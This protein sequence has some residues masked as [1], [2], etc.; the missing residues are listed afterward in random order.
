MNK[1]KIVGILVFLLS[2]CLAF[3]F[4]YIS[5]QNKIHTETLA[6]I[7]EQKSY[8]QEIS[9]AVFYLSKNRGTSSKELEHHIQNFIANM[10]HKKENSDEHTMLVKKWKEFYALVQQFQKENITT[11]LYS[12]ILTDTLVN[13][14]YMKN[15]DIILLFDHFIHTK[16]KKYD[17]EIENYKRLEY[18]LFLVIG[19]L[20]MY[21][22]SQ[23]RGV[24]SFIYTFTETSKN[25][26]KRESIKGLKP[27]KIR[28][29]DN[30]T[31]EATQNY[32]HL[33]QTIDSAI[34]FSKES[35]SHTITS[36]EDT[37]QKIENFMYLLAKMQQEDSDFS[38]KE[39]AVIESL[40]TLMNLS[41]RLKDLQKE[42]DKLT[43]SN[44]SH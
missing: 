44:N 33:V 19:V 26:M 21:L 23:I 25:I 22:F 30:Y 31:K 43:Y 27:M 7:H 8:T 10:K 40:D 24:M 20:L 42:L 14:I 18:I 38:K 29:D 15:Q 6:K 12:S 1:I 41:E 16:E 32:N 5:T 17:D 13:N 11:T 28:Q 2:L 34:T 36:L 39:D 3:L 35:I 4:N 37:E 9:K